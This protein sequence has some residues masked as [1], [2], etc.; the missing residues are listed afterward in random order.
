LFSKDAIQPGT[1][2]NG[3]FNGG[4]TTLLV[5]QIIGI[6]A[7][8]AFTFIASLI[9]WGLL[10]A[11]LGVRVSAEE[12]TEGLDVGEHGNEA[13]PDFVVTQPAGIHGVSRGAMGHVAAAAGVT[14]PRPLPSTN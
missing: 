1:A 9:V 11:T 3:L 14:V 13:Y 6:A 10:K 12:E 4:G 2:G 8:G 7:V 5:S